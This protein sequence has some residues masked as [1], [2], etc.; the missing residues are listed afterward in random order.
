MYPEETFIAPDATGKSPRGTKPRQRDVELLYEAIEDGDIELVKYR[1][2]LA[3]NDGSNPYARGKCNPLC[4]CQRCAALEKSAP[5]RL[6]VRVRN[7]DGL[8]PLHTAARHGQYD[9]GHLLLRHGALVNAR[10]SLGHTPLHFAAQY[11]HDKVG[12]KEKGEVSAGLARIGRWTRFFCLASLPSSSPHCP[13][14]AA[15]TDCRAA[16][17]VQCRCKYARQGRHVTAARLL[18][19]RPCGLHRASAAA[20]CGH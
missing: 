7:A 10:T 16:A 2:S 19:Q 9:I 15:K 14:P 3:K 13:L 20:Q 5:S 18:L 12:D 8:T 11:N 6:S 17:A 1:L 4:Q